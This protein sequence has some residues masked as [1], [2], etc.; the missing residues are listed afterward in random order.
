[1]PDKRLSI[2][3]PFPIDAPVELIRK[4]ANFVLARQVAVKILGR[5]QHSRYQNCGIDRREFRVLR[6]LP[7]AWVEKMIVKALVAGCVWLRTL[8]AVCKKAQRDNAPFYGI[9][10]RNPATFGA[11]RKYCQRK[12]NCRDTSWRIF[13]SAIQNQSIF[14]IGFIQ[15]IFEGIVLKFIQH[16]TFFFFM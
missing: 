8:I 2:L 15:K 11:N 6:A 16:F 1:M 7:R 12:A 14:W 10:A 5:D 13:P 9:L 3:G 4:F